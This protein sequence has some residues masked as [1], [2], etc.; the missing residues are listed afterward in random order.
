MPTEVDPT[1]YGGN[2]YEFEH[3]ITKR[4]DT[5]GAR[6]PATGL[7]GLTGHVSAT[8]GGPAIHATLST[9]LQERSAK[10]GTYFG[11]LLGS[12][13]NAHLFPASGTNYDGQYVWVVIE[14]STGEVQGNTK[15]KAKALRKI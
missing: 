14:D 11:R 8:E 12:N 6:V 9:A 10:P 2:G 3:P 15:V 1:I 13:I 7:A 4:D 5:T